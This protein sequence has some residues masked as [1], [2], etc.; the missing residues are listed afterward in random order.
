MKVTV[1]GWRIDLIAAAIVLV[2]LA[3]RVHVAS[4]ARYI[5]DED[6]NYIP[7]AKVISFEPGNLNLPMRAENHGA[8]PAYLVKASG[9]LFGTSP[10]GYRL[11]HVLVSLGTI[12]FVFLLARDWYGDVAA[13]WAA[14]LI[15]FNEYYLTTSARVTAHVPHLFFVSA[16][17]WAF[18][19][20]LRTRR[21]AYLYATGALV[22]FAFYIKEHSVLM[23]PAFFLTLLLPSYRHWLR[24][25]HPY[26]ACL[27][28]VVVVSPD[29]YWNLTTD[30]ETAT[31]D[32]GDQ[33]ALQAT[34]TNH[35]RRIGGVGFSPYPLMYYGRTAV[36]WTYQQITGSE[37][38]DETAEYQAMNPVLGALL[39]T[40]VF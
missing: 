28:F 12:L 31:V 27:A 35:L 13:R 21:L 33:E 3:L 20:F 25:P 36:R 11:L 26:L 17:V 29:I 19:S 6:N 10:L 22:G 16:T 40:A 2:A 9:A 23:L 24:S 14:A 38:H 30:W 5:H 4:S 34:Y 18:G 39:L 8:Y 15:A 1:A 37:L 7:L 32:Y